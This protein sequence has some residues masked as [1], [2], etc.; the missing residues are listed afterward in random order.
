MKVGSEKMQ[1]GVFQIEKE[2]FGPVPFDDIVE[3]IVHGSGFEEQRLKSK[4]WGDYKVRI[5]YK[6]ERKLPRWRSF[7]EEVV[8]PD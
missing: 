2:I 6:I 3:I 4:D 5:Y 1:V 7:F 8:A